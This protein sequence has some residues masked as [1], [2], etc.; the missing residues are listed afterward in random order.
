M[1]HAEAKTRI[2]KLRDQ[3]NDYRYHYHVLDE[4]IMSE[5]ASD[6]LKH[7]LS[8]LEAQFPDLITPDSPTQ[9]VAGTPSAKFAKIRHSVPMI[10]LNDV[11]SREEVEA[12]AGRIN[13][14]TPGDASELFADTK[15]DGLACALVYV[16]GVLTQAVTRGDGQVG[17]DVT[18]QVRTIE[19][20]PLRLRDDPRGRG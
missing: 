4:S 13:K 17:E 18:A 1:T 3:I 2:A 7:E 12:W 16:D 11:F 10:S 8:Q 5:A 9:R 20:V 14:L 15:M 6:S 19:N